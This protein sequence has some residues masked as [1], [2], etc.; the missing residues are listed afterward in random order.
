MKTL[1]RV[2]QLIENVNPD[3]VN[4]IRKLAELLNIK[5]PKAKPPD[6]YYRPLIS[7]RNVLE[8]GSKYRHIVLKKLE[9]A[10][11]NVALFPESINLDMI[12]IDIYKK[13]LY[14]GTNRFNVLMHLKDLCGSNGPD[15]VGLCE[16]WEP[17]ERNEFIKEI[18]EY[19]PYSL[20][21]P[22][23]TDPNLRF[24]EVEIPGPNIKVEGPFDGGLLLLS[25][26]PIVVSHQHIYNPCSGEDC[27]STKGIFHARIEVPGY[28]TQIDI[29]ITHMQSCPTEI[30]N[31]MA[32]RG[33]GNN[34][35]EK[36]KNHQNP[37]LSEFIKN[38]CSPDRPAVLMGDL[39]QNARVSNDYNMLISYLS[40]P[41]DL[42]VEMGENRYPDSPEGI[43]SDSVS[44]FKADSEPRGVKDPSRH[45]DGSRY[46]YFF[47]WPGN[48]IDHNT[49]FWGNKS[50]FSPLYDRTELLQLQ[51]EPGRDLSDHYGL[52]TTIKGI[53]EFEP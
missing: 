47:S 51:S 42:W 32:S 5:I 20:Q 53:G 21:G 49:D 36:L 25:R 8:E 11:Q 33:P 27:F 48:S 23:T 18:S 39:N 16:F 14:K 17:R 28:P 44:S 10:W 41:K 3:Q 22:S 1:Q 26:H 4:T 31:T 37:E 29:F 43:T 12:D 34:C 6:Y 24:T 15:I 7:L 45:K 2:R 19:Y 30:S 9:I 13:R 40:S 38:N 52:M 50:R 35:E 46:D